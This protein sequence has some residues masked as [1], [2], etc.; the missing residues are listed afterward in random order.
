MP[1]PSSRTRAWRT[2]PLPCLLGLLLALLLLT[3]SVALAGPVDW[4]AVPTS[5]E[6]QQWWD[7]GSLRRTRNGTVS[8]LSRYLPATEEGERPRMGD[9][10]VM[11]LDCGQG[12][13]RDTSVNG[14]PRFGSE[15]QAAGGDHLIDAV[16]E[17]ACLAAADLPA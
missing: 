4:Q 8:V 11:E 1:A 17:A 16:I 14:L 12:L 3:P 2:N 5:E 13:Y 9:L 7:A 10:Y 15:W 6:G